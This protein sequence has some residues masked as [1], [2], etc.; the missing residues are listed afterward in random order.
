M[1]TGGRCRRGSGR[2]ALEASRSRAGCPSGPAPAARHLLRRQN[3]RWLDSVHVAAGR[4]AGGG[5]IRHQGLV[6][7][8][9][10]LC[11]AGAPMTKSG[12]M[13]APAALPFFGIAP[14]TAGVGPVRGASSLRQARHAAGWPDA[15]GPSERAAGHVMR[16]TAFRCLPSY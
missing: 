6:G 16:P 12:V 7:L 3:E 9:V 5:E 1:A 11:E 14:K 10:R 8:A 2:H 13:I 15:T 4:G